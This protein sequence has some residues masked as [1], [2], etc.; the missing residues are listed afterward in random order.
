[1]DEVLRGSKNC[2]ALWLVLELI[3]VEVGVAEA[4]DGANEVEVV[5][6]GATNPGVTQM[7]S[8]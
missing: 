8:V 4:V 5:T 7:V 1:M 3:E 6:S 2:A